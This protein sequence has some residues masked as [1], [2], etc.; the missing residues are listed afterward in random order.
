MTN[1][2]T[3]A[4]L[5]KK[6]SH[7]TAYNVYNMPSIEN[8]VAYLHAAAGFPM[9]ATWLK[10]ICA[11]NFVSWPLTTVENVNKYSPESDETQKGHGQP[12]KPKLVLVNN[13][14]DDTDDGQDIDISSLQGK[15]EW[16]VCVRM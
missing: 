16:D 12:T 10:V 8:A 4:I 1:P 15:K 13:D 7:D 14:T 6:P 11:G 9:K 3:Q 5:V 2:N